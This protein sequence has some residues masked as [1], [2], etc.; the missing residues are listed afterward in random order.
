[1]A[2]TT[3]SSIKVKERRLLKVGLVWYGVCDEDMGQNIKS[4]VKRQ[5]SKL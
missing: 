2:I 1:M 3:R 5:K 4:K